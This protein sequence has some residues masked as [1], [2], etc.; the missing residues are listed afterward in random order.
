[1][2]REN[3]APIVTGLLLG[4]ILVFNVVLKRNI[5]YSGVILPE[6]SIDVSIDDINL[7]PNVSVNVLIDSG[8]TILVNIKNSNTVKDIIAW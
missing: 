6:T 3:F 1:M 7:N 4:G 2:R 5:S 8:N